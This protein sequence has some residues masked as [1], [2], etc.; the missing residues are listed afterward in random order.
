[1][2]SVMFFV[3]VILLVIPLSRALQELKIGQWEIFL[4]NNVKTRDI[5]TGSF[6]GKIPLYVLIVLYVAPPLLAVF[7]ITFEVMLVG[8]ILIYFVL[9]VMILATIWLSNLITAAIQAK[10]GE[11]AK[12]KDI[13][14]GLAILLAIITIIPIYGIMFYGQQMSLLLGMNIFLLLPFT[15]PADTISWLVIFFSPL[16]FSLEE[17]LLFQQILQFNLLVSTILFVVFG[18]T[19]VVLGLLSADRIFTYNIGARTEQI[20]TVKSDNAF[21]RG[22]R[23]LASGSFGALVVTSMKDFFRKASN[24]SKIA[25]G[26][27]LAVLLPIVMTHVMTGLGDTGGFDMMVLFMVGGIGLAVIGTFTFSGTSFMESKDQLWI[28]QTTPSGTA[29]FVKARLATA[30]IIAI[31]LSIIPTIVLAVLAAASIELFIFLLVYGYAVICGSITFAT[32]VTAWNPN[33][34]NTKSPEHQMNVI[35][36]LMGVQLIIFAPIMISMFGDIL[37][38]PFWDLIIAT[39]G[40]AGLPFAFAII[41][42]IVLFSL[43]GLTLVIGTRALASPER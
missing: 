25:Y 10:L 24:L 31:P 30:F 14:N 20:T 35:I 26:I 40:R 11:S 32:G 21:Y 22:I 6:L 29:R 12:G 7:F 18:F 15:W 41:G 2:R 36:S 13:A 34:E 27:I 39:V 1:M 19:C 9:I 23:K 37:G 33:Y 8:Q 38:L 42:L 43:S 4:S 16:N 17:L 3:F 28:I 5:L